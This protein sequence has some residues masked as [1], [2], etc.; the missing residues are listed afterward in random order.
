MI[1]PMPMPM[2]MPMPPGV[3]AAAARGRCLPAAGVAAWFSN[4]ASMFFF[5]ALPAGHDADARARRV[6]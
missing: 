4:A 3:L 1:L 5:P 6:R 2:P